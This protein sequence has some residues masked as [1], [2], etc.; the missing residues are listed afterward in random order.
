MRSNLSPKLHFSTCSICN[1]P[2]ELKTAKVDASG[3]PVHEE[4][5]AHKV[6]SKKSLSLL[7]AAADADGAAT[8]R[9]HA[10][11][12]VLDSANARPPTPGP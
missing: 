4:C 12:G 7:S 2:V 6:A 10:I 5:F 3:Q 9:S 11:I 1:E 8:A